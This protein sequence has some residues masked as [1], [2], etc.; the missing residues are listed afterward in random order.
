MMKYGKKISLVAVS[1][2]VA[3]TMM[4][5]GCD[6]S[7][8]RTEIKLSYQERRAVDTLYKERI[9]EL[10]PIMDSLCDTNFE[11]MVQSSIDSIL[12]ERRA[13]EER[14]RKKIPIQR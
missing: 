12:T 3:F 11:A 4:L 9:L 2:F 7:K 10:A 6:D 8:N 1:F 13:E 14:L 5:T